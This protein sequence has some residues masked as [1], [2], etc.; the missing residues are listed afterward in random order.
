MKG[1]SKKLTAL[2]LAAVTLTAA[3]PQAVRA[4]EVTQETQQEVQ[5]TQ[6]TEPQEGDEVTIT[7]EDKPYLALGGDLTAD[8]QHKVLEYMGIEASDFDQYDVVYVT[9]E[10][11]HKYLDA[12]VPKEKIGTRALSSVM[13]SLADEGNGL[14]VST[15]NINY[16]TAGMYKNALATAGVQDANVIVAGPFEL[17]GT[18]ALVGTLEAYEK[19][20]GEELN[21]DVVDAAMDELVTTGELEQ[22]IDGDAEDVEAM[23]ADLKAKIASGDLDTKEEIEAAIE[24]A[25]EKYDLK[26]SEEDK[27]KILALLDKLKN[28]DLDWDSIASQAEDWAN[29]LKVTLKDAGVWDQ[30]C[31]FFQ[32]LLDA[33][34]S[35]FS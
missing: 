25:A 7:K 20:T 21:E 24:E 17:S 15:Y 2:L 1:S 3:A 32:K 34:K 30:I 12:Y 26:L 23:I 11:E 14:K 16:C 8:Q 28:L 10:E 18:A 29:Q 5:Q 22:S 4:Q 19:L 31:A 9:N 35:F 13:I 27:G 33:I 6:S